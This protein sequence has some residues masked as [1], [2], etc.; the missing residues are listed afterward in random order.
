VAMPPPER[1]LYASDL[2]AI[3]DMGYGDFSRRAAAS[4]RAAIAETGL[5]GRVVDLGCGSGLLLKALCDRG[6]ET[7]GVD[8]SPAMLKLSRRNAPHARLIRGSAHTCELPEAVAVTALGEVLQYLPPGGRHVPALPRLFRRIAGK[9]SPGGL[10]IFD[11]IVAGRE[12]MS[13]RSWRAEGSWAVLVKVSE[14]PDRGLLDREITTFWRQG[15]RYRRDHERHTLQ[16][17]RQADVV[18]ALRAT[19]FTV[20]TSRGYGT[21]AVGPRRVVFWARKGRK[22]TRSR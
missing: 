5:P 8:P 15:P 7:V 11:V 16:I 19:G 22:T 6:Y 2:A 13:Y 9:L 20:R 14:D 18:T 17:P 10:L 1:P 21:S 4:V 3:H 12:L